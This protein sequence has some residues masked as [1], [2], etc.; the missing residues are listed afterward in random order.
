MGKGGLVSYEN[1]DLFRLVFRL[2]GSIFDNIFT[3]VLASVFISFLAAI[4]QSSLGWFSDGGNI[5]PV[6][7]MAF[8]ITGSSIAFLLVFRSVISYNRFWEGRGHLGSMMEN[9]RDF[10]RQTA[11]CVRLDD[12]PADVDRD[13][14]KVMLSHTQQG[15]SQQLG[16]YVDATGVREYMQ[17]MHGFRRLQMCRQLVMFWR[18]TVQHLRDQ[19]DE[20]FVEELWYN[21]GQMREGLEYFANPEKFVAAKKGKPGHLNDDIVDNLG[22]TMPGKTLAT[23][24]VA[25]LLKGKKRRP[26]V[27]IAMLS[28]YLKQEYKLKNITYME[29]LCMNKD[30]TGMIGAFNGVDKVHN[31]P[32]PFPYAQMITLLMSLYCFAS[33]FM[34]VSSFGYWTFLPA[35]FLTCAFFGINEVALEIEDPFGNDENDLPL[36]TM[37]DALAADCEMN[38]EVA[39]VPAANIKKYWEEIAMSRQHWIAKRDIAVEKQVAGGPLG[40]RASAALP[41]AQP[42][43]R[44]YEPEPEPEPE[45]GRS[46]A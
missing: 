32:I 16:E 15:Q 7:S 14:A 11:F 34:F 21:H 42:G 22:S 9:A 39:L 31:V 23:P 36:D 45:M 1:T 40:S 46:P 10:A 17:R 33:P 5:P 12:G 3:K 2:E 6:N 8:T 43:S 35:A 37:G 28:W 30:L 27:I 4:L 20:R 41:A 24:H 18:L 26:L 19:H 13:I 29:Y 44:E 25:D 38:L